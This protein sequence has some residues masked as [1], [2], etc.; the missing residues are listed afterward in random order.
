MDP[1]DLLKPLPLVLIVLF[2]ALAIGDLVQTLTEEPPPQED[3]EP[4]VLRF[5]PEEPILD[6]RATDGPPVIEVLPVPEFEPKRWS[7]PTPRG[8]WAKGRSAELTLDLVVGGYRG[9]ILDCLPGSGKRPVR[10]VRLTVN[11]VDCGEVVLHPGWGTYRI[12]LPQRAFRLGENRLVFSFKDRDDAR[13]T[14]RALL[15]RALALV[16]DD[17]SRGEVPA[18]SRPIFL[19]SEAEK[20]ALSVAGTLEIPLR[21]DDRTDALRM[22]YRF[23][24]N[25]GRAEVAV[26]QMR[27][28]DTG[29][30]DAV[31]ASV[32]ADG[33]LSGSLRIPLHGRR[34]V[35]V[36]RIRAT[37]GEP[38]SRLLISSLRLT[39]EGDPT[40][41]PWSAN[42]LRD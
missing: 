25:L 42:P 1:R 14:R 28:G 39:E 16:L 8:V 7:V 30:H 13:K 41:R 33:K 27:E 21:L 11:Q 20:I 19:D 26:V 32:S 31:K 3:V 34:G 22:R 18:K 35:Y 17:D 24:S 9:L 37:P 29:A 36:L 23:S 2:L 38:G 15:V 5:Q 6:F 40:G 4:A 10:S 12:E